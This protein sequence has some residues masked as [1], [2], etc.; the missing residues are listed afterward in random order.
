VRAAAALARLER[1]AVRASTPHSGGAMAWRV[2][3]RGRPLVLLHGAS[4]SWAHWIR[5]IPSLAR[6]MRVYAADMPGFGDSDMP[7]A[8]HTADALA[9]AVAE[10]I[11][12]L[13][14]APAP[15]D[16]AGFSFGGIIG[17]LVAARLGARLQTLVLI[18]AGGL[19]VP[20]PRPRPLVRL[21]GAMT[22]QQAAHAHRENLGRLMFGNPRRVDDLAVLVQ[23]ENL[24][25]ARFKS[26]TIPTSSILRDALPAVRARVRGTWGGRDAFVGPHLSAY[27][28]TLAAVAP[29]ATFRVIEGAGH[30]VIYEAAAKVNAALRDDL[31]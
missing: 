25:R 10:A 14:P 2:W 9:D 4:G 11:E 17:G 6:R 1:R 24:R 31:L 28:D 29:E 16:L 3:G 8:P 15:L 12:R 18:G 23:A 30:W 21:D 22:A 13:V 26:G 20:P 5:N 27:R 19:G 7:A